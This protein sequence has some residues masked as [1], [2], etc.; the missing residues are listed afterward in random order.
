[1]DCARYKRFTVSLE[2]KE[3]A[4]LVVS[5][6][7]ELRDTRMEARALIRQA[8]ATKGLLSVNEPEPREAHRAGV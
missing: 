5:A 1:M 2:E 8:L 4:A 6:K 3:L 7:R